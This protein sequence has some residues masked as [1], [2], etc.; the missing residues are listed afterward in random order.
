VARSTM[1]ATTSTS[2]ALTSPF[3]AVGARGSATPNASRTI[4]VMVE[5]G[6]ADRAYK[7]LRRIMVSEGIYQD[8]RST[9]EGH[10]KPSELRVIARKER[11]RRSYRSKLNSKLGWIMRRKE[12]GF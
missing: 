3:A 9:T 11:E 10:K 5:R 4:T 2:S 1:L 6:D 8:F 7:R 12:R